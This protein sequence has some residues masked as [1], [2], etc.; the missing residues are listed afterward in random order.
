[1]TTQDPMGMPEPERRDGGAGRPGSG[2]EREAAYSGGAMPPAQYGAGQPR[3]GLGTAALVCGILAVVLAF[4]PIV[5][6][7][8]WPL[9]VL[10][11]VFSAVG[12]YRAN[13]GMATNRAVAI[14]GTILGIISFFTFWLSYALIFAASAGDIATRL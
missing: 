11:V 8:T 1:M 9:G 2:Y 7:G 10:A 14:T 12:W 5:N 3:N 6:W 4:I 13:K